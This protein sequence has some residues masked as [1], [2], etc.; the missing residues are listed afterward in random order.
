MQ[1][2]IQ[3]SLKRLVNFL[4]FARNYIKKRN[5]IKGLVNGFVAMLKDMF[6]VTKKKKIAQYRLSYQMYKFKQMESLIAENNDHVFL[7]GRK[8][9]EMR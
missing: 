1:Q 6:S 2:R 8:F 5:P 3:H 9:N 4:A 7:K